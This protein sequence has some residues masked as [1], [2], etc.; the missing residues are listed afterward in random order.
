MF[1]HTVRP[2]L[3]TKAKLVVS[4]A[5][6]ATALLTVLA[7]VPAGAAP[8]TSTATVAQDS[9][10]RMAPANMFRIQNYQTKVCIYRVSDTRVSTKQ[11][12][13]GDTSQR[14]V[15]EADGSIGDPQGTACLGNV[16]NK[17]GMFPC[18]LSEMRWT[19][20]SEG[21]VK[22]WGTKKCLE[23]LHV[24]GADFVFTDECKHTELQK[25]AFKN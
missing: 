13:A 12:D 15:R 2:R 6:A 5:A 4:G 10:S 11:C 17:V 23:M 9:R 14:W 8:A 3:S 19:R 22:N 16:N 25:W 24:S 20:Y 1:T 18:G 21:Y 7:P